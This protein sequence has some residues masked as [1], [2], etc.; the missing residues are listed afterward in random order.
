VFEL[1]DLAG[2]DHFVDCDETEESGLWELQDGDQPLIREAALGYEQKMLED[3]NEK[4]E[5][6]DDFL[7]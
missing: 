5:S 1:C 3:R 7:A 6:G 2:L 4:R